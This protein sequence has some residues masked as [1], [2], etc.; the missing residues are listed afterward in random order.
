MTNY[1]NSSIVYSQKLYF[2]NC[3]SSLLSFYFIFLFLRNLPKVE[4]TSLPP[5]KDNLR[6]YDKLILYYFEI[7]MSS[8]LT[9]SVT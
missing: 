1:K 6:L 9:S 5:D 8:Q 3:Q 4:L 7:S 2:V